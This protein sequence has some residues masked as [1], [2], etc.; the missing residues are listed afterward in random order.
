MSTRQPF[1]FLEL[2]I[3]IK[4]SFVKL[5]TLWFNFTIHAV[6]VHSNSIL[7]KRNHTYKKKNKQNKR[8][9]KRNLIEIYKAAVFTFYYSWLHVRI[10]CYYYYYYC[11]FNIAVNHKKRIICSTIKNCSGLFVSAIFVFDSALWF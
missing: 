3:D 2:S 8:K 6:K 7:L 10:P 1:N 11:Y 5:S 4:H 9:R